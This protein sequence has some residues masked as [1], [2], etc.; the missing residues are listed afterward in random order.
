MLMQY[1][2]GANI[3]VAQN[4][5]SQALS[6]RRVR[7]GQCTEATFGRRCTFAARPSWT[8]EP[9]VSS[10]R[11]PANNDCQVRLGLGRTKEAGSICT[12]E[13]HAPEQQLLTG[14]QHRWRVTR[15]NI[16]PMRRIWEARQKGSRAAQVGIQSVSRMAHLEGDFGQ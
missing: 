1:S 10:S 4:Q 12:T 6:R 15:S 13:A 9:S 3:H 16:K 7:R 14:V 8:Q 5:L 11:L 2:A